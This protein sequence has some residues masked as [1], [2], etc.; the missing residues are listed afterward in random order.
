LDRFQRLKKLRG[1]QVPG[2][3]GQ[4][5]LEPEE[6]ERRKM[7]SNSLYGHEKWKS[8][9]VDRPFSGIFRISS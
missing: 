7:L 8:S 9:I 6:I 3:I 4:T 1:G 2:G 5:E